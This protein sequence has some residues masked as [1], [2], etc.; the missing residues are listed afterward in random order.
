[1]RLIHAAAIADGAGCFA[2]PG[3]ILLEGERLVAA[4]S[5]QS[6]GQPVGVVVEDHGGAV[7]IPALVNAHAHLD[8]THIGPQ[9]FDGDFTHWVDMVRT[10]RGR[11]PEEIAASVRE[12]VRRARAGGTAVIGDIAGVRSTIPT[13]TMREGGMGGVSYL[14]VFGVGRLQPTAIAAM[15]A[16]VESL[17]ALECGV[18]VGIQPHAP[19]SCGPE[20]YRAAARLGRPLATHLA[21]T[22]DELEFVAHG[23]G[24]LADM[25]GRIGV[26]DETIT[27]F[28]VHPVDHLANLLPD[29]PLMAAHLNYLDDQHLDV[30]AR[31]PI[32]VAYCPRASAYFGH[33]RPHRYRDMLQRGINVALGTDSFICLDTP[34][35]ISVLDEMRLLHRRDA[36]DPPTLLRM[37]TT[38]GANA[39][40]MHESLFTL[41]PGEK[42]GLLALPVNDGNGRDALAEAMKRTDPPRWLLGPVAGQD[43]W[44]A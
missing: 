3:A 33:A 18:K 9:L 32:T 34:D 42:A 41:A 35:R 15:T 21:E 26:W 2:A 1:M 40:G 7:V 23:G 39:L 24:A 16:A 38:S 10:C 30:L 22:L 13:L 25:L 8:L 14:E 27:G 43:A 31:L 20:M 4:G 17:P 12:G 5:P 28:G 19:Y 36:I 11:L 6:I 44:F 37:A 29:T